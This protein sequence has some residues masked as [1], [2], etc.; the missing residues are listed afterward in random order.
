[1]VYALV[2]SVRRDTECSDMIH[3]F[4]SV[5]Y[6]LYGEPVIRACIKTKCH[7][8]DITG[9]P[10]VRHSVC[11]IRTLCSNEVFI[12]CLPNSPTVIGKQSEPTKSSELSGFP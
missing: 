3:T 10:Y 5:Q 11:T 6:Q 4:P 12:G 2:L 8:V 7:Y 1:M 9:E